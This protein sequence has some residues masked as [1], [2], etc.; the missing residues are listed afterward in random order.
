MTDETDKIT[1]KTA[2]DGQKL[3]IEV[4]G[5]E[6]DEKQGFLFYDQTDMQE[7]QSLEQQ[8]VLDTTL[9]ETPDKESQY[10]SIYSWNW[11]KQKEPRHVWLNVESE[12]KSIKLPLFQNVSAT[13]RR[14]KTAQKYQ[15]QAI[16]PLSFMPHQNNVA[17]KDS[18]QVPVRNGYLYI[19]YNKRIWRELQI[20]TDSQGQPH[21]QDVDLFSYRTARD[22]P[23]VL[24]TPRKA[25][26]KPLDCIW[27]PFKDNDSSTNIRIAFSEVPWSAARLNYLESTPTE[28]NKRFT[29]LPQHLELATTLQ[30]MRPRD[31]AAEMSLGNPYEFNQD[32]TGKVLSNTFNNAQ[33]NLANTTD[34]T[35]PS[36]NQHQYAA[37]VDAF[38]EILTKKSTDNQQ[39]I[40]FS[41]NWAATTVTDWLSVAKTHVYR[42]MTL[43]D[44]IQALRQILATTQYAQ[45]YYQQLQKDARLQRN[46]KSAHLATKII[47]PEQLGQQK[48]KLHEHLDLL[49]RGTGTPFNL[50]LRIDER[51]T[52]RAQ[53]EELKQHL[54]HHLSDRD[55]V[56]ILK[57]ITSLD[58][59]NG[60]GGH[61]L[62]NRCNSALLNDPIEN[63]DLLLPEEKKHHAHSYL[64][65]L[66]SLYTDSA[67]TQII[68]LQQDVI[69]EVSNYQQPAPANDGT[70]FLTLPHLSQ[71]ANQN[72]LL[73]P[74]D[75]V[76]I[77]TL[78]IATS[79]AEQK[80]S[81]ESQFSQM[82]R[83]FGVIDKI[84]SSYAEMWLKVANALRSDLYSVHFSKLYINNLS[85]I[86]I[87]ASDQFGS[88]E[89]ISANNNQE[90]NGLLIGLT[91]LEKNP[92]TNLNTKPYVYQQ[93][94]RKT[95]YG[96][97]NVND[98]I[99]ADTSKNRLPKG[100]KA[101]ISKV[102]DV[103][104]VV[105]KNPDKD[106]EK[107]LTESTRARRLVREGKLNAKTAYERFNVPIFI[108]AIEFWNLKNSIINYNKH[109][110]LFSISSIMSAIVD[111]SAAAISAH[112][113]YA[114]KAEKLSMT[115][116]KVL[117]TSNK[118]AVYMGKDK[119]FTQQV[120]KFEFSVNLKESLSILD[121]VNITAGLFT[122]AVATWQMIRLWR[123]EDYDAA[124]GMGMVA[125]G[126]LIS[127]LASNLL[128]GSE[129]VE[130]AGI[131]EGVEA[132]TLGIV[133]W[134]GLIIVITGAAIVY[135][136][137]DTNIEKWLKHG[138]F[139]ETPE[140]TGPYAY[141]NQDP[142]LAFNQLLNLFLSL[143]AIV[144]PVDQLPHKYQKREALKKAGITHAVYISCN[145]PHLIHVNKSEYHFFAQQTF[146][147][148]EVDIQ[149]SATLYNGYT[150]DSK[151][152]P[153]HYRYLNS[154]SS[155]A[156]Q[157]IDSYDTI[158]GKIYL[159]ANT[160]KGKEKVIPIP[161][162]GSSQKTSI[163]SKKSIHAKVQLQINDLIF[164]LPEIDQYQD[165]QADIQNKKTS[166]IKPDFSK[167]NQPYWQDS[168]NILEVKNV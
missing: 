14:K 26:G 132:M 11:Q 117:S 69:N 61:V 30:A 99:L 71:W 83:I 154:T 89:F 122:V 100:M 119:G 59:A 5:I 144:Y 126:T 68:F 109:D 120:G 91:G 98:E 162:I 168:M 156:A 158:E 76:C 153:P 134:I 102:E 86:K 42:V 94:G 60:L 75:S 150:I 79:T 110:R 44:P 43:A 57:D 106:I 72:L 34:Q 49:K 48:N 95:A 130:G 65:Q 97:A 113:F 111:L 149:Q 155:K 166:K 124:M 20:T 143:R 22:Q 84:T 3:F 63:D 157:P 161:P 152:N 125:V 41:K 23:F 88:L 45:L 15:L 25:T 50:S 112:N 141:L 160:L 92:S 12:H 121:V 167:K 62:L 51:A 142:S 1:S 39:S 53:L 29:P 32:L 115:R 2:C 107:Y 90:L 128:A 139:G 33:A 16:I 140:A 108:M 129:I 8:K 135:Y 27:I 19:V 148:F 37:Q 105:L 40:D 47:F 74:T 81:A 77:D 38:A 36:V 118:V 66:I 46:F 163:V 10:T 73:Q 93:T 56:L 52:C 4:T 123:E 6:H 35:I 116:A 64:N 28:I 82:R 104:F 137:T 17:R 127:T 13:E 18:Q 96:T 138:P 80:N 24:E 54:Y 9:E 101:N 136:F 151:P 87:L 147:S 133:S 31:L 159:F 70:G 131:A 145:I 67:L 103:K 58:D 146:D 21:F 78:T 114:M 85:L 55:L 7:L 165:V 164:P